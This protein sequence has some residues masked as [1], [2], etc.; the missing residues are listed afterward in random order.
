VAAGK[1]LY[2]LDL[3]DGV[4]RAVAFD[5]DGKRLVTLG[6]TVGRVWDVATGKEVL[7]LAGP[8]SHFGCAAFSPDGAVLATG[9][10]AIR[11]WD[12]ATGKELYTRPGHRDE[13]SAVAALPTGALL[14]AGWDYTVRRWNP[15]TGKELATI[16]T[17][18]ELPSRLAVSPDG[19]QLATGEHKGA[20]RLWDLATGKE[21]RQVEGLKEAVVSLTY[22]ADGTRLAAGDRH[23]FCLWEAGTGKLQRRIK[24]EGRRSWSN[25][26]AVTPDGKVAARAANSS[27]IELYDL[28]TEQPLPGLQGPSSQV[29]A[30]VFSPDG[31]RL[32]T[33]DW[34]NNLVLWDWAAGKKVWQ[35]KAHTSTVTRLEFSPD[36]YTIGSSSYDLTAAVWETATGKLRVQFGKH[37]DIALTMT[38]LDRGRTLAS[39]G[40]DC[41][42]LVWDVTGRQQPGGLAPAK[43][44]PK[45]V[46]SLW[47]DLLSADGEKAH[48]A[49]WTL[50]SAPADALP[51]LQKQLLTPALADGKRLDALL[52]DLD[53]PKEAV[54]AAAMRELETLGELASPL[55]REVMAG[56]PPEAVH[57]RVEALLKKVDAGDLALYHV[58]QLRALEAIEHI[59]G[60]EARQVLEALAADRGDAFLTRAAKSALRRGR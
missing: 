36:G 2:C 50:A 60:A 55:L 29:S 1:E 21:L 47:A 42:A 11:L 9:G 59:G 28:T 27:T 22:L 6:N 53:S 43:L 30:V 12:P 24:L 13:I 46:D 26:W 39:A 40:R 16:A 32:A 45:E 34:S 19:K 56:K 35:T 15:H 52:A 49:I 3:H 31:T 4:G 51:Y 38:F 7:K 5:V 44:T 14:T 17:L 57:A 23:T 48:R 54:A 10:Q 33:V 37:E 41:T 25:C 20:V 58:R 18:P 8:K